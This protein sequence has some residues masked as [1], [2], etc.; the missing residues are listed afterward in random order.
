[1]QLA[2]AVVGLTLRPKTTAVYGARFPTKYVQVV[3]TFYRHKCYGGSAHQ[4]WSTCNL[5]KQVSTVVLCLKTI[6]NT[7]QKM[8][9]STMSFWI[10]R[11]LRLKPACVWPITC[12]SGVRDLLPFVNVNHVATLKACEN[13]NCIA[14]PGLKV[15]TQCAADKVLEHIPAGDFD[16]IKLDASMVSLDMTT[17]RTDEDL[18]YATVEDQKACMVDGVYGARFQT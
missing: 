3:D 10:P 2:E 16:V 13:A 4:E 18:G 1:M 9:H 6:R 14:C 15:C 12:L 17:L 8:L 7:S 5:L 11:L